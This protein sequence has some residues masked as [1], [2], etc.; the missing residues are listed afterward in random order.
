MRIAGQLILHRIHP[1]VREAYQSMIGQM[2]LTSNLC[3]HDASESKLQRI[4][5]TYTLEKMINLL[6]F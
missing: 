3:V 2:I 6:F 5:V 4:W 1:A